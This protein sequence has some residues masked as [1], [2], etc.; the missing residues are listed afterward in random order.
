[1]DLCFAIIEIYTFYMLVILVLRH[2]AS[3][4]NFGD[5]V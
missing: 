4:E 5:H 3:F 1:M 2:I